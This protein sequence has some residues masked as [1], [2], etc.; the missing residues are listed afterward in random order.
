MAETIVKLRFFTIP[1]WEKEANWLRNMHRH[2]EAGLEGKSPPAA[3]NFLLPVGNTGG[4]E[5]T[6][7]CLYLHGRFADFLC[8]C[9]ASV[10]RGVLENDEQT[11]QEIKNWLSRLG[12]PVLVNAYL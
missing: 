7:G 5:K 3:G 2:D 8:R 12:E 4:T 6:Y 1:Q 9:L 10:R 11:K